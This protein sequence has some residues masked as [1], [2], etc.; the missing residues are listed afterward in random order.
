MENPSIGRNLVVSAL[1]LV[2]TVGS[3]I[4]TSVDGSASAQLFQH[5]VVVGG[6]NATLRQVEA[7][8]IQ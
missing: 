3:G 5:A 4:A 7:I 1:L 2:A 6:S 8:E